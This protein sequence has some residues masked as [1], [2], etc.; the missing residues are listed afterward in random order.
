[1]NR[2]VRFFAVTASV[3]AVVLVLSATSAGPALAQPFKPL[4][5]FIINDAAHPV[6]VVDVGTPAPAAEPFQH[7]VS[8]FVQQSLSLPVPAGKRLVIEFYSGTAA[9][10]VPCAMAAMRIETNLSAADAAAQTVGRARGAGRGERLQPVH[11]QSA[12]AP[13]RGSRDVGPVRGE[14]EPDVSS[15]LHGRGLGLFDR[16]SV[17]RCDQSGPVAAV[18]IRLEGFM[19]CSIVRHDVVSKRNADRGFTL[20]ELLVVIAIIAILIALLVPA[21]Q[22]VREAGGRNNRDWPNAVVCGLAQG[23][24]GRTPDAAQPCEALLVPAALQVDNPALD[25]I[26][27]AMADALSR[28]TSMNAFLNALDRNHD[29]T[30][31]AGEILRADMRHVLLAMLKGSGNETP[32]GATVFHGMSD[33]HW[34]ALTQEMMRIRR[35]ARSEPQTADEAD[36]ESLLS[37][38]DLLWAIAGS[39]GR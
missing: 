34:H 4:M 35:E 21:V 11:H 22:K 26:G 38:I 37:Q 23:D 28:S 8:S 30:L 32:V 1:M 12:G 15:R 14:Y 19:E 9:T 20:I 18:V 10:H 25:F 6:P 2:I 24:T 39:G 29:A 3:G 17:V 16:R 33:G 36:Q 27:E 5:A 31:T 13:L 7:Q